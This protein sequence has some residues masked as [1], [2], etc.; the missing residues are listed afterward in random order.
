MRRHGLFL[1]SCLVLLALSSCDA[2]ISGETFENLPPETALSVRDNS[3][4]DN[5]QGQDPLA[6]T[7]AASWSGTD[8]DG[9]VV[10]FEV[11]AYGDDTTPAPTDG[12]N[13]TTRQDSLI[14]LPIPRGQRT[15]NVVLEVRA[16]DNS[17]LTDP[18]PARTVFP[19]QNAPPTARFSTFSLPPDTT[20][21]IA[22]FGLEADDPEGLANLDRLEIALNDS[23]N[24]TAVPADLDFITLAGV[25]DQG[26]TAQTET[27]AEVFAGR[28]FQDLNISVPGLLL[29]AENTLYMRAVD[30]T[31]T[32]S[33]L[34]R[35][36]WFV[37]KPTS[38]VLY[39]NDYR[40]NTTPRITAYHLDLL[41][42]HLGNDDI[43]LWDLSLP[44]GTGSAGNTQRSPALP[45]DAEPMLSQTF[46]LY[47]YIYWVSTNTISN[48]VTNN[49]PFA[50]RSM[51]LFFEEGG[52]LMV[53]S[54]VS[55]P[56]D[57]EDNLGNPAVL[58]LPLTDIVSFPDSLRPSLR[59]P[60]NTP[61]A[62]DE[63]APG[64]TLPAL[65]A[66]GIVINTLPYSTSGANT[67]SLYR[68]D[69]EYRTRQGDR[70]VW[71]GASTVASVSADLRVGLFALPLI[72][73][74]N[75]TPLLVGDDGNPETARAAV[76]T[77]L[78]LLGF[79]KG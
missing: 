33:A 7:V 57:P 13:R 26:N 63:P 20:F 5:L 21:S 25:V 2:D 62:L 9:Y 23:V 10:A 41:S 22:S 46:A 47:D 74:Q 56:E 72:N 4:V 14:L 40:K 3:L 11:R 18:D 77:M 36:T 31:D 61:I 79:P 70:G 49:L 51:D 27:T 60:R 43:D 17:G 1:T 68:A 67:I 45:A 50:A 54:P 48:Q 19:I 28:A 16:I 32:T 35:H 8:A 76:Q 42:E 53:H 71:F 52:K 78:D 59:L 69:Y 44:Y 30:V 12:W 64:V 15:A 38:R 39:V 6:S 55:V 73:E 34:V 24:F 58:L 75:G 65:R 37:K 66:E 29:D